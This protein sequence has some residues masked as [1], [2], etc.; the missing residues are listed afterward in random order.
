MIS[1]IAADLVTKIKGVA[2]LGN[3][4]GLSVGG[5]DIDPLLDN[6]PRPANWVLYTGTRN[7]DGEA[8]SGS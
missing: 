1:D 4:V 8:T 7:L 3:R 5:R 2:A 6:L